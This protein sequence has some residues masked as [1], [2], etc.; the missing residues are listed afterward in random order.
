MKD[1]S[2]PLISSFGILDMFR[3]V[4]ES[5]SIL[6]GSALLADIRLFVSDF[7]AVKVSL[8]AR[9]GYSPAS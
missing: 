2:L 7:F 6:V 9:I 1:I 4:V 3:S 5:L 8:L